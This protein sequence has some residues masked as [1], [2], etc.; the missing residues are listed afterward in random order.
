[1]SRTFDRVVAILFSAIGIFFIV[2]SRQISTSAYGSVV[3][4]N[5]FPTGLGILL[6]L[7]SLKLLYETFKGSK[8]ENKEEKPDYKRFAVIFASALLYAMTMELLGYILSTFL[9]LLISFQTM[10]RGNW[11]SSIII[12]LSFSLGVYYVYVEILQGTLPG[13]PFSS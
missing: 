2:Q 9:F 4:P 5:L 7:L 1:L 12:A 6:I 8:E 13:L 11:I 10:E 3:G